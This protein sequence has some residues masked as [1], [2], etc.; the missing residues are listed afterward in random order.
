M[1]IDDIRKWLPLLLV[2][3]PGIWLGL[4]ILFWLDRV[5]CGT[6]LVGRCLASAAGNWLGDVVM[7]R[8]VKS[9]QELVGGFATLLG[10]AAAIAAVLMQRRWHRINAAELKRDDRLQTINWALI[11]MKGAAESAQRNQPSMVEA[12]LQAV[13]ELLPRLAEMSH[14]LADNVRIA[15]TLMD[16]YLAA[17]GLWGVLLDDGNTLGVSGMEWVA[18]YAYLWTGFFDQGGR[19]I[20]PDGT[21][22]YM[23][24]THELGQSWLLVRRD[25][26]IRSM[27]LLD[28]HFEP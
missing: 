27:P 10:A 23:K 11:L 20:S 13:R 7:L 5:G 16:D 26:S 15:I 8:W 25:I 3:V 21:F 18:M 24:Q 19:L 14:N 6:E 12:H 17:E 4:Y 1:K 2:G 28:G 9:H 22:R